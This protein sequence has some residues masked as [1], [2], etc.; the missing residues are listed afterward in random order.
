L[1]FAQ[2]SISSDHMETR[3]IYQWGNSQ[4]EMMALKNIYTSE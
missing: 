2:Q 1:E 4:A 3:I